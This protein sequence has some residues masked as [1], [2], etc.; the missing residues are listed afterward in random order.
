MLLPELTTQS[1]TVTHR[2]QSSS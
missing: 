1:K 2:Q